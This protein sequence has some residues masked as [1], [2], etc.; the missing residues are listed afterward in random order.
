[1]LAAV[2]LTSIL[3]LPVAGSAA[4]RGRQNSKANQGT[5]WI[6]VEV[7][8]AGTDAAHISVNLPFTLAKIA[9]EAAP[10]DFMEDDFLEINDTTYTIE[11]LRRM[12]QAVRE[13]GDAEFVTIDHEGETVK[14][15]RKGDRLYANVEAEEG[16]EKVS[17]EI[18]VAVVD[19]L[20]S[21]SGDRLD[22]DAAL[23]QLQ[24]M[25]AGEILR[26]D[27]KDEQVRVWIDYQ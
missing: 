10:Q 17:L 8:E 14:V 7:T 13:V 9:L 16:T 5:A 18:P 15:Y 27:D 12:W 2:L 25:D 4:D 22:I 26:V 6:H 23:V 19:A 24:K 20:L 21:G 11:D 3:A 1:M